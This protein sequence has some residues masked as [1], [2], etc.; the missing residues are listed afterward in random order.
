MR[1]YVVLAGIA[2]WGALA[3]ALLFA[4]LQGAVILV[5]LLVLAATFELNFFVHTGVERIGRYIQV[6]L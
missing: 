4:D 5:P 1:I 2:A 6:F 3:V